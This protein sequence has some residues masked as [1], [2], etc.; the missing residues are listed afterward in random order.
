MTHAP[1]MAG[2]AGFVWMWAA[3]H[4]RRT[5]LQWALLGLLAGFITLIRWQNA[6][7]ALLPAYEAL[8]Q[9]V[10]AW[11]DEATERDSSSHAH[12]GRDLHRLRGGRVRPADARV[13]RDLRQLPRG[14]AGRP[15]DPL[16]GS[17]SRRHPVVVAQRSV[18]LV[19]GPLP[20]RHRPG[21]CSP[22]A[23]PWIGVPALLAVARD[24]LL[25]RLDPGL[26]GQRGLRRPA[27]RRHAS[28]CS[29]S[30]SRRSPNAP[31]AVARRHP[32]RAGRRRRRRC[33][34]LWNLTLMSAAQDGHVRIGEVG[35]VRRSRRPPGAGVPRLV[36]QSV[37]LSGQPAVRAAQRRAD[38]RLRPARRPIAS[39]AIRCSRTA[40]STSAK[41]GTSSGSRTAGTRRSGTAHV[42]PL[43][44]IS[45]PRS[46]SHSITPRI[47][48]SRY[49]RARSITPGPLPRRSA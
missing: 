45:R 36:R 33:S 11:R 16:V 5:R 30:A 41:P 29:R 32:L 27:L 28:R 3:T 2:V 47:F 44:G 14:V 34:S 4:G 37:H 39:S 18:Q 17:A 8:T 35:V 49:G 1:S 22:F 12:R 25:Q 7:F 43:G 20:R 31:P 6:L 9:L 13:E 23:R 15:A 40:G 46:S 24:D 19:A 48:A 38:R 42:V 21:R 10:A 26:V